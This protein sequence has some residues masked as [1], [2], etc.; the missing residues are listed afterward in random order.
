MGA[1]PE[2]E[3]RR[4][5]T[6]PSATN[7]AFR[8]LP[9]PLFAVPM[10][11]GGLGLAWREAGRTLGAPAVVGEALLA[12]TAIAWLAI[13]L[14]HAVRAAR[15]PDALAADLRH[16][17]RASF[18]GAV[19]IGLMLV[20]AGAAPLAPDLAATLWI[21]ASVL[22]L[23]IG[24]WTVRSLLLAPREQA[25]L[26]PPLLIPLV[27]NIL[28]PVMGAKLGFVLASWMMF[29]LG[30]LLWAL[31]QPLILARLIHGPALPPRLRPSLA[32][33]L[34][35]PA[36]GSI[37][38]ANLTGA[39]GAAP[40]AVLGLALFMALVLLTLARPMAQGPF[41]MSW[42]SW[43]FP[44]AAFTVAVLAAA[45]AH[46]APWQPPLLWLLLAA[47][48]A[49]VTL[50]AARTLQAAISGDLLLPEG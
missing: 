35:P 26:A 12:A 9:L 31:I 13:L 50:V 36:V 14:L 8:H 7:P 41:A 44:P 15:H 39:F 21:I 4:A 46:P 5:M 32:I 23:A 28:A 10:G 17:I 48:S 34:A 49:V 18:A 45:H 42:W 37:A 38:L 33:L 40:L 11:L 16:P 25:A 19:S 3:L 20:A 29:G 27:G 2:Q 30:A 1:T 22:H 47:V 6:S 24:I 43:T